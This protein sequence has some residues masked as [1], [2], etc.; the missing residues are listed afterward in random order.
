MKTRI[1]IVSINYFIKNNITT[2]TLTCDMQFDKHPAY[3]AICKNYW[4]K[5]YPFVSTWGDFSV[6]A[7][8][9]CSKNDKLDY[10]KGKIIA[11]SKAKIKMFKT[12]S[13]IYSEI[14]KHLKEYYF[15]INETLLACNKQLQFERKHYN[16][17]K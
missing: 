8:V 1:K 7:S 11:F 2:C 14:N 13:K 5:K 4:K 3:S 12:A 9:K 17:I 15:E 16:E 10:N 6:I